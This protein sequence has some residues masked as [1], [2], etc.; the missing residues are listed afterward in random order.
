MNCTIEYPTANI[1]K[2]E[3]TKLC[4]GGLVGKG[5]NGEVTGS[6]ATG[7]VET[8]GDIA[9]TDVSTGASLMSLVETNVASGGLVGENKN[10]DV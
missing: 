2:L 3:E 4:S 9:I 10:S 7:D 6:Y 5:Q 1:A 8:S